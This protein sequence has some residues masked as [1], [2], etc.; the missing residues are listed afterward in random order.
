MMLVMPWPDKEMKWYLE[1]N[2]TTGVCGRPRKHSTGEE[3]TWD[4]KRSYLFSRSGPCVSETATATGS[5]HPSIADL[6]PNSGRL[7]PDFV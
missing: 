4:D 7:E 6:V 2:V 1:I 3:D 5:S